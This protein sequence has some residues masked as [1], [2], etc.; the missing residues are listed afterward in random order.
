MNT[1]GTYRRFLARMLAL[2]MAVSLCPSINAFAAG[3]ET[4]PADMKAEDEGYGWVTE[5]PVS[6]GAGSVIL[7]LETDG[8]TD[9]EKAYE[10]GYAKELPTVD[11]IIE[12][13]PKLDDYYGQYVEGYYA[14]NDFA[15]GDTL[16][17][18]HFYIPADSVFNQPTVFI[19]V[20]SDEENPYNFLVKS[21][22]KALADEKGLYLITMEDG[23]DG[24]SEDDIAYIAQ[25]AAD[26]GKRPF[27]CTFESNFYAIAYGDA[28]DILQK[29]SVDNP[30][31]WA[32]IAVVGAE[33]GMT[34]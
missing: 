30:K 32:A 8:D 11:Y 15:V 4:A 1:S 3:A 28:A 5:A 23:G 12:N 27:F 22:W 19:G 29:H 31:T 9:I 21:G 34:A 2:G 16:R 18:A 10:E 13:Y 17:D 7:G 25:L 24:W 6:N 14:Y 26:V 20:P 33:E